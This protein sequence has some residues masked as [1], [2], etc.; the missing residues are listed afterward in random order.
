MAKNNNEN[1]LTDHLRRIEVKIQFLSYLLYL[2]G[3]IR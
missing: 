1:T 2:G 3:C